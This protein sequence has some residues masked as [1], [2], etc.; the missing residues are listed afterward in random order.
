MHRLER[1]SPARARTRRQGWAQTRPKDQIGIAFDLPCK[2]MHA[3]ARSEP[4][5]A[6]PT[7]IPFSASISSGSAEA[8]AVARAW[9]PSARAS[10]ALLVDL[11]ADR[12]QRLCDSRDSRRAPSAAIPGG[13]TLGSRELL[14]RPIACP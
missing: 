7:T 6:E 4:S 13:T 2:L 8:L 14:R 3:A 1:I 12:W 11:R 10:A 5:V 9:W